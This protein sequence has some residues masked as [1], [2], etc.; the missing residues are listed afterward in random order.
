MRNCV[1]TARRRGFTLIELLVVIAI[2]AILIGLLVPAVQKVR[3]AA[4][5]TQCQNNLKQLALA[6]HSYVGTYKKFPDTYVYPTYN[7]NS[8]NYSYTYSGASGSWVFV[9]LPYIEQGVIYNATNGP[10]TY[11]YSYSYSYTY[12]GTTTPYN[13]NY[14]YNYP[15]TSYQAQRAT[16][17]VIASLVNPLD[18]TWGDVTAPISYL[19]NESVMTSSMNLTK[20][21]DGTSNTTLLAEGYSKCVYNYSYSYSYPGYSYSY[22][23]NYG[24]TRVWNYDPY[25]YSGSYVYVSNSSSGSYS[26]SYTGTSTI[27]PYYY[28]YGY[29]NST[30]YTYTPF[31]VTPPANQADYS[32]AQA[33]SSGGLQVA[34]ADGSVRSVSPSISL[35]T[36][37]AAGTPNSGDTLGADWN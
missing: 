16:P 30:T 28:Y 4:A 7:Y 11:K 33:S 13:Y 14:S 2:I 6:T 5:R 22:T 36:W 17:T 37:Q 26:Y 25:N 29:Y 20:I 8:S 34:L 23:S 15:G 12:N 3:E 35:G 19:A 21:T 18:P 10:T 9:L 1:Q 27:V 31:Q 32:S 24:Y